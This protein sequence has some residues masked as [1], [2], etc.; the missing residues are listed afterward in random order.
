MTL[1]LWLQ[2]IYFLTMGL[3]YLHVFEKASKN[4]ENYSASSYRRSRCLA[5]TAAIYVFVAGTLQLMLRNSYI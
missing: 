2:I 5:I 4:E 3:N 1:V